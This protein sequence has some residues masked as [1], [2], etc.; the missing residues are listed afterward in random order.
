LVHGG[1]D[2]AEATRSIMQA[3]NLNDLNGSK[4]LVKPNFNTADES[5][6]S[7][8]LDT[9]IATL[10][11]LIEIGASHVSVG[12][13]SGPAETRK[14]FEDKGI[15][16]LAKKMGFEP[17]IFDEMPHDRFVKISPKGSHW[18]NGFLFVKN[19]SEVDGVIGLGCLKTHMYGGHFTLSLKLA[20]GMVH[21][22]NMKELHASMHMREMIADINTAYTPRLMILDGVEA[23]YQGGPMVGNRWTADLTFA[24]TDRVAL[25]AVGVAALKMHG[26][27]SEI[28]SR[29][30]FQQDQIKRAVQLGLGVGMA[31][32]IELRA[33]NDAAERPVEKLSHVL[34]Y[35]R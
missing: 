2:R 22:Q 29:G 20:T 30:I 19:A 8:H 31:E 10:D 3:S 5:P 6:G 14:V 4:V 28:E 32:D 33:L 26:T 25:D 13:R 34:Y 12:D 17:V 11:T 27:T 24:S 21:R 35:D 1:K 15:F 23:F 7:T 9:L 18:R 16:S